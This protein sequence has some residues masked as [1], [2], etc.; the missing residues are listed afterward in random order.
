MIYKV[1]AKFIKGKDKEFLMKLTN[2]TIE[3]QRPD[4]SEIIASM[5]RAT[6]DD[7]GNVNW[8]EMCFCPTPLYHE[9]STIYD[10]FFTDMKTQVVNNHEVFEGKSFIKSISS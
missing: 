9:R 3:N 4:G 6:I 7:E 10:K 1:K 2:G 8:T 5:N